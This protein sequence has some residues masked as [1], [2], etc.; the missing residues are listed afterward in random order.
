MK[1]KNLAV[2][3][4]IAIAATVALAACSSATPTSTATPAAA[5]KGTIASG[6]S[7]AQANAQTA[8]TAAFQAQNPGVTINYDKSQGSGGGVTNFLSG[9][10]D[11]AGTDAALTSDQQTQSQ[12]LC[13]AGGALDL[14]VYLSGV[15]IIFNVP[16]VTKLNL[17]SASIAK[18][19]NKK[20]TMWN[21]PALVAL[22]PGVSVGTISPLT[23]PSVC[24]QTTVSWAIEA[25]PIQRFEPLRIQ[26]VPSR[27]A[28][29][30]MLDGSDPALGSVRAKLPMISPVAIPGSQRDFCSSD[31][32]R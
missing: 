10:Y 29:V 16:G 22:N 12:T 28:K 21:D 30:F 5:L 2:A 19:F 13:G 24:A 8:W 25:S 32:L 23:P 18:I 20:I 3:G 7:S 26:S 17:D 31:P 15:A 11:F 27:L 4:T 1:L 6:G 14:P 9:T